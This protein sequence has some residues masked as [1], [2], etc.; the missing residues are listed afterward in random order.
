MLADPDRGAAWT[1]AI[2]GI[3]AREVIVLGAPDCLPLVRR[4]AELCNEPVAVVRLERKSPL[5]VATEAV[6]LAAITDADAVVAF[7]RREVFALRERLGARGRTVAVIYGALG[8]E[9]RRA[10]KPALPRRRRAHPGRHGRDRHGA[11][12]ADPP[13]RV[14]GPGEMGTDGRSGR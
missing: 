8:P 13:G 14:L 7:S 3:P 10:E 9:V 4:I 6:G 11:E 12:P 2:M 5:R 1:A